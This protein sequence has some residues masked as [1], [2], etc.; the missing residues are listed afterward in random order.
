MKQPKH[1]TISYIRV[2]TV[3]Q[4][5]EKNR[6]AVL[7]YANSKNFGRVDFVEEKV[8]GMKSWRKRK[9]AE[10]VEELKAGD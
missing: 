9:L 7:T 2:S 4:D 10:I 1:R 3:E 5:T 8:S 6:A